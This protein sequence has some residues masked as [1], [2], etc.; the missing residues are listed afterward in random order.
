M[1]DTKDRI[2]SEA[3]RLLEEEGTSGLSMRRL[4]ERVGIKAASIYEHFADKGALLAEV[5]VYI[6]IELFQ[7]IQLRSRNGSPASQLVDAGM[8]YFR[9]ARERNGEF[10]LLFHEFRSTRSPEQ[11]VDARSPYALLMHLTVPVAGDDASADALA[12]GIWSMAHGAAVLAG[13]HLVDFRPAVE[14]NLRRNLA[15]LVSS[16]GEARC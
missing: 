8:A 5:R 11:P 7:Y 1:S 15:E 4:A 6:W 3:V 9:F 2:V 12:F 14:K 16:Y 10:S 13:T